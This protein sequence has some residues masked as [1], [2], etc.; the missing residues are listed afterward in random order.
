M[1]QLDRLNSNDEERDEDDLGLL[2]PLV[3]DNLGTDGEMEVPSDAGL[4]T[5]AFNAT[6][7]PEETTNLT[8]HQKRMV[9]AALLGNMHLDHE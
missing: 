4:W 8:E 1:V 9:V 7:F 3:L 2:A 5:T 6:F